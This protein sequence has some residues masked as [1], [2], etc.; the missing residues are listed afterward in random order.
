MK[1]HTSDFEFGSHGDPSSDLHAGRDAAETPELCN[2]SPGEVCEHCEFICP[3]CGVS[4]NRDNECPSCAAGDELCA[5]FES[6]FGHDY[7][8][9]YI[10]REDE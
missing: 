4:T 10:D 8:G 5:A 7:R 6:Y 9:R 3:D 1:Q 2:C